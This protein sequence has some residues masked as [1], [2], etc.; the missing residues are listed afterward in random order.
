MKL[1]RDGKSVE[2]TV[3][4]QEMISLVSEAGVFSQGSDYWYPDSVFQA[5]GLGLQW[6]N[7]ILV[8]M[9]RVVGSLF[10]GGANINEFTGPIGLVT[11][12]DQA[13]SLGLRIVIFITGFISLNLGVVNMIPF[14][15]LDGEGCC[16]PF[17][18]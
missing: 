17:W 12:V 6:A 8:T 9:V 10:T 14:P 15:A 1:E 18:R 11:I 16:L 13:I 7:S 3:G 2:I 5:A 4:K